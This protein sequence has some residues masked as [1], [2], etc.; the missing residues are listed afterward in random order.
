MSV[1]REL[2]P[3][4]VP[5][6]GNGCMSAGAGRKRCHASLQRLRRAAAARGWANDAVESQLYGHGPTPAVSDGCRVSAA[7]RECSDAIVKRVLE[8]GAPERL[9]PA[10]ALEA[11]CGAPPG[12]GEPG[13]RTSYQQELV[14][15][16]PPGN[17][18]CD[19]SA[20]LRGALAKSW[21]DWRCQMRRL[22]E[23]AA[24]Q[25]E[26]LAVTRPYSDPKLVRRPRV[27]AHF[28][29]KLI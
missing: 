4:P 15:L 21:C 20:L 12:Y 19:A 29:E 17:A 28:V 18:P 27:Y 7:Q 5:F 3:C 13:P 6:P 22:P 8:F 2:L 11:L 10:E 23:D 24:S 25:R 14:S 1:L 16:P 9:T 26:A